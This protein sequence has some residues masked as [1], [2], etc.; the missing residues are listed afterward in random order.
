LKSPDA[1]L[2]ETGYMGFDDN[3]VIATGLGFACEKGNPLIGALL[4]DYDDIPFV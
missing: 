3:G 1:L 2:S 4:R